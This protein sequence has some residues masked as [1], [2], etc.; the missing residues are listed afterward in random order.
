MTTNPT[1]PNDWRSEATM[2]LIVTA[3]I[4]ETALDPEEGRKSVANA[5]GDF[6]DAVTQHGGS[7]TDWFGLAL[8]LAKVA[9][10]TAPEDAF[11]P[12]DGPTMA[13]MEDSVTGRAI[14]DPDAEADDAGSTAALAAMRIVAAVADGNTDLAHDVFQALGP[15]DAGVMMF[16]ILT[17]YAAGMALAQAENKGTLPADTLARLQQR[18]AMLP[19]EPEPTPIRT[20]RTGTEYISL[21]VSEQDKGAD[22]VRQHMPHGPGHY[23]ASIYVPGVDG[24]RDAVVATLHREIS[25]GAF[26]D[27]TLCGIP[28]AEDIEPWQIPHSG[29]RNTNREMRS[30]Q[31]RYGR[32]VQLVRAWQHTGD[33]GGLQ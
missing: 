20:A 29:R 27:E 28:H 30:Q 16:L 25:A 13:V 24:H 14:E 22:A 9:V 15:E 4:A 12:G 32:P 26:G 8:A 11:G 1:E 6:A 5:L 18:R 3:M 10:I 7:D 23:G 2:H 19:P 33:C 31:R 17:E 21:P